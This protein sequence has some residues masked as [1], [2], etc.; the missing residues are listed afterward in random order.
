MKKQI[1]WIEDDYYSINGLIRPLENQGF[2]F[3]V[4]ASATESYKIVKANSSFDMYI[5]DM[6][7]PMSNDENEIPLIVKNWDNEEHIGIGIAKWLLCDLGVKRPVL[8][9][10]V[11]GN[12]IM[13]AGLNKY[14][15]CYYLSKKGLLPSK[16]KETVIQIFENHG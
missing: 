14:K 2:A 12:P 8:L 4:A 6:I 16:V 15:N 3:K 7:M 1:L 10:S 11:A 13:K 9:M 5:V